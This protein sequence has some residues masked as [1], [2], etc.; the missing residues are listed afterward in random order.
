MKKVLMLALCV[1]FAM[2]LTGCGD[3]EE[4]GNV[5]DEAADIMMDA[6]DSACADYADCS[7]C[8]TTATEGGEA[9]ACEGEVAD[10]AQLIVDDP[11]TYTAPI[12]DGIK[13]ACE[14]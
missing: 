5:C 13:M 8:D 10:G 12:K 6:F 4:S 9:A 11:D 2:A 14:M 1:V 7:V 3:D